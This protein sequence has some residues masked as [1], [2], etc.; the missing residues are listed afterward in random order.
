MRLTYKRIGFKD[1]FTLRKIRN[2]C[3]KYMTSYTDQLSL[4]Q[5]LKWF[6]FI[7]PNSLSVVQL[8]YLKNKP[9]G[10]TL[11]KYKNIAVWI[12]GGLL[13]PYRGKGY[14][15]ELFTYL[16]NTHTTIDTML[17]VRQDN[18]RAHNLYKSLGFVDQTT[19]SRN[20]L[21]I[22]TM[23]KIYACK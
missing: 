6:F 8:V 2:N 19:F 15:R 18:K 17:E 3:A 10:Y 1:I 13:G 22:I 20:K 9:I 4:W 21:S 16:S 11:R 12:T 7:Y 14:G 5:Q 23:K